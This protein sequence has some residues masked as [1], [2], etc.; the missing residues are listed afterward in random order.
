MILVM[1][2]KATV[3]VWEASCCRWYREKE[4][5]SMELTLARQ[6]GSQVLVTCDNQPSHTF[7]LLTLLPQ[8]KGLPQPLD[9]PVTYGQALYAALFPPETLA[10]RALANAPE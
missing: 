2:P 9:D 3:L 8:E 1:Y 4:A 6:V 7:D 10:Q 5:P